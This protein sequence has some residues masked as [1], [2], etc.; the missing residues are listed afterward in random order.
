MLWGSHPGVNVCMD[1]CH[2]IASRFPRKSSIVGSGDHQI[3]ER[4][5]A[6]NN[7]HWK[8]RIMNGGILGCFHNIVRPNKAVSGCHQQ[9]WKSCI[10]NR[11]DTS[12]CHQDA[13]WQRNMMCLV[14]GT[15]RVQKRSLWFL[16]F[17]SPVFK[18][19]SRNWTRSRSY[20]HNTLTT[21]VSTGKR[22]QSIHQSN[23]KC[24]HQYHQ[25]SSSH[26]SLSRTIFLPSMVL[27]R[28]VNRSDRFGSTKSVIFSH[29]SNDLGPIAKY[30]HRTHDGSTHGIYTNIGDIL[31]VNVAIYIYI[32]YMDPMGYVHPHPLLQFP[33]NL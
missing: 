23:P 20:L 15:T 25:N 5:T 30:V 4:S 14:M 32:A 3:W 10:W 12:Y 9:K 11:V 31:M 6:I 24:L 13:V 16:W 7:N 29:E 18:D 26:C 22:N 21:D 8:T 33:D 17:R 2:E 28:C 1:N 19:S 27:L